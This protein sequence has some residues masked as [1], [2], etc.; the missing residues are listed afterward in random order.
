[1]DELVNDFI[2]CFVHAPHPQLIE[3]FPEL[4]RKV[5]DQ[6]L[7]LICQK[8]MHRFHGAG[9][10]SDDPTI[11]L[12]DDLWK[13]IWEIGNLVQAAMRRDMMHKNRRNYYFNGISLYGKCNWRANI[14]KTIENINMM[15]ITSLPMLS[16]YFI[17]PVE[18]V[19]D[20]YRVRICI[21]YD[22]GT[23]RVHH[24]VYPIILIC[25]DRPI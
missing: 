24:M 1:M 2:L 9:A 16:G 12:G 22:M 11:E 7:L 4:A 21:R 23:Y 10:A 18:Q 25:F 14:E 6:M 19:S 13:T 3:A 20:V 17:Y 15:I 8:V 5:L